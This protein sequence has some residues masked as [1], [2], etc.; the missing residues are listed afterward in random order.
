VV[1]VTSNFT[2]TNSNPALPA[3]VL[4]VTDTTTVG[5]ADGLTLRKEVCNS[6]VQAAAGSSCDP[7]LT[8]ATAGRGFALSNTGS[9]NDVLIYRIIYTNPGTKTST[10]LV[11]NDATPPYTVHAAPATCPAALTPTALGTCT[12]IQPAA[13]GQAGNYRWTFSGT[14]SSNT[15]GVVLMT[16]SIVPQ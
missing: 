5:S 11:I 9:P 10:N 2:Y 13:V 16:V 8:G 3:T 14:L 15:K 1:R 4:A 6:T 12:I 7:S